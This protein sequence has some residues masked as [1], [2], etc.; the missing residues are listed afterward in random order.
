MF[1]VVVDDDELVDVVA[2]VV[3]GVTVALSFTVNGST[4]KEK[5]S[6]N[7]FDISIISA[8]GGEKI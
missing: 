1:D 7:E 6:S 2:V 4:F 8:S 5:S 3:F